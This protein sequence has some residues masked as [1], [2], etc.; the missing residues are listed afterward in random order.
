MSLMHSA[1]AHADKRGTPSESRCS[2]QTM[3]DWRTGEDL[4]L[5]RTSNIFSKAVV[6]LVEGYGSQMWKSRT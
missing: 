5:D 4:R 1:D 2:G 3:T 6:C